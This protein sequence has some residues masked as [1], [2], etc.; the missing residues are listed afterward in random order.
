MTRQGL[1]S[2]S[3]FHQPATLEQ[4]EHPI[5][6]CRETL[7]GAVITREEPRAERHNSPIG[8]WP[9]G[10]GMSYVTRYG[11][12]KGHS[13]GSPS[14]GTVHRLKLVDRTTNLPG[15]CLDAVH[16]GQLR[17]LVTVADERQVTRAARKLEI[18]QPALSQAI[19]QLEAELGLQLLERDA[20]G[21]T[22]TGRSPR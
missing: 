1:S 16:A 6:R 9:H 13:S 20:R 14:I 19:T 17:Y 21:V 4:H 8:S 2:P 10:I 15:V 18:A 7:S 3:D 11:G 5:D 12:Q 22:L